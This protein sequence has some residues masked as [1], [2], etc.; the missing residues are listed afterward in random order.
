MKVFVSYRRSDSGYLAEF[1]RTALDEHFGPNSA[2][3]DRVHIGVGA[4]YRRVLS[5]AV[6]M[7]DRMLVLIGPNWSPERL[8]DESD[9]VRL[10]LELA[11]K[12]GILVLPVLH[13]DGD[14]PTR[15]VLPRE[16]HWLSDLNAFEFGAPQALQSNIDD[17]I[18][19]ISPG[20]PYPSAPAG[21]YLDPMRPSG[22]R[23]WDGNMWTDERRLDHDPM[24]PIEMAFRSE[25]EEQRRREIVQLAEAFGPDHRLTLDAR[26]DFGHWL[27][28]CGEHET[29]IEEFQ[30]LTAAQSHLFGFADNRTQISRHFLATSLGLAGR[31]AEACS[32]FEE[33]LT[34]VLEV[35]GAADRRTHTVYAGFAH[36]L[37]MSGDVEG[38]VEMLTWAVE[39]RTDLALLPDEE[40]GIRLDRAH[41]QHQSGRLDQ[42]IENLRHLLLDSTRLFGPDHPGTS[43]ARKRLAHYLQTRP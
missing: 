40:F 25:E 32:V 19:S 22:S 18:T 28:D 2:F 4:D 34:D 1:I 36:E 6:G 15:M 39:N 33:L 12:S 23:F 37:G 24:D 20:P 10:E 16:L 8:F 7:S 41:W 38:A 26:L 11:H 13:T 21:W 35:F 5:D 42:A 29:A 3:L 31:H 27:N 30:A 17:L 14:M 43:E 9:G